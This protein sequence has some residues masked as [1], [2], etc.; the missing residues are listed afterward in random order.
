[1]PVKYVQ[2]GVSHA[3]PG[4]AVFRKLFRG[5]EGRACPKVQRMDRS[6]GRRAMENSI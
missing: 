1:M 6:D 3:S 4:R 2:L 5:A